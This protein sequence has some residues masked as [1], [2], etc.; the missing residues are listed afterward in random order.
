MAHLDKFEYSVLE[1]VMN[2]KVN[3]VHVWKERVHDQTALLRIL[4]RVC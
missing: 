3:G 2:V 1:K 4:P